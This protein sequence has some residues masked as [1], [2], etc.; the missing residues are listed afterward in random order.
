MGGF[1]GAGKTTLLLAAGARL[2][3]AGKRVGIILNDQGGELVD[4]RLAE[5]AGFPAREITGGCFCCRFSELVRA[6]GSF[7]PREAPDVILAEPVGSCADLAATIL[8]PL[9]RYYAGRYRLAPLTVL[10]DPARAT[11]LLGPAADPLSSYLFEKQIAE[12][13]L[14]RF[15]KADLYHEF[16]RIPGIDARPLS[17]ETGAGVAGWLD[18]VLSW[19]GEPGKRHLDIDYTRY[20][21]AEASLGWLN[22]RGELRLSRPLTPA[23]ILGP[24]V[25]EL[26]SALNS[27]KIPIAHLK[28]FARS[29][30][31]HI[32]ASVCRNGERP[33]VSGTLDAL[34][35]ARCTI[36]INLRA[37]GP[38]DVLSALVAKAVRNLPGK[39][40]SDHVEAFR[41]S[42]PEPEHRF[43]GTI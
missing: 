23:A 16:P 34:P 31:G 26:D 24:L 20:A 18:E 32:K 9:E 7:S 40:T 4:M 17:A 3:T 6:A 37:S 30:A 2:R 1:L 41:P 8:R 10:V 39:F 15:S 13:D 21:E 27:A 33:I 5:S 14:V 28:I 19:N 35:S 29:A 36:T 38:P 42:P 11:E 25:T 12:A 43:Q 22:W